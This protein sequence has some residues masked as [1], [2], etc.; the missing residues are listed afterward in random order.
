MNEI[1]RWLY[2]FELAL[3]AGAM[4]VLFHSFGEFTISGSI[5]LGIGSTITALGLYLLQKVVTFQPYSIEVFINF[6]ALCKDLGLARNK[7][8]LNPDDDLIYEIYSFTAINPS[9]FVHYRSYTAKTSRDLSITNNRLARSDDEYRPFIYFAEEIPCVFNP[10]LCNRFNVPPRFFFRSG[11][12]GY[13]FGIDVVLEWWK[14]YKKQVSA[15]ICNLPVVF[16][17]DIN[18]EI[19]LAT[20]PY[21]YISNH[22]K[23]WNSAVSPFYPFDRIQRRWKNKLNKLGWTIE[24]DCPVHADNRYVS[25]TYEDFR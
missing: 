14:V 6:D 18:G 20:M 7:K 17:G 8:P 3:V 23:R 19:V 13:E 21:G 5:L 2:Q 22:V 11:R 10:A 9:V 25:I 16:N 24:E 4:I 15:Q 12:T 1:K